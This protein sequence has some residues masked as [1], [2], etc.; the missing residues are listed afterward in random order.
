VDS[1]FD[2]GQKSGRFAESASEMLRV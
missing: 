1:L 2:R